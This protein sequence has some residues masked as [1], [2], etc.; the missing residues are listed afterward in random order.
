MPRYFMHLRNHIDEILDP[1]GVEM[2]G[3]E[4]VK[5]AVLAS[6]RDVMVGDLKKGLLDLRYRIDA[7]NMA[8]AIIFT[9]PF[10]HAVNI[11]PE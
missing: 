5:S 9:L 7:E 8:G 2:A 1:E 10:K 3:L 6:A 11:I 4:A